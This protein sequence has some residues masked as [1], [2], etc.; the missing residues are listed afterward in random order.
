MSSSSSTPS[1]ATLHAL[2]KKIGEYEFGLVDLIKEKLSDPL[3][4]TETFAYDEHYFYGDHRPYTYMEQLELFLL[5]RLDLHKNFAHRA[6][7]DMKV[8]FVPSIEDTSQHFVKCWNDANNQANYRNYNSLMRLI[9]IG[10]QATVSTDAADLPADAV[11]FR[12]RTFN[13]LFGI[14]PNQ[15]AFLEEQPDSSYIYNIVHTFDGNEYR[16]RAQTTL[17][18]SPATTWLTLYKNDVV[19]HSFMYFKIDNN[20][21]T[22]ND[23]ASVFGWQ[24]HDGSLAHYYKE[25]AYTTHT[26]QYP[27]VKNRLWPDVDLPLEQNEQLATHIL[28]WLA[29]FFFKGELNMYS[30]SD[31]GNFAVVRTA[32]AFY[33]ACLM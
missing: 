15:P 12:K 22:W 31:L 23:G 4:Q 16:L 8:V 17:G 10:H 5:Q 3:Q 33:D 14:N 28:P 6:L 29:N 19:E 21:Y 18:G 32:E 13:G 9:L 30:K 27:Q 25:I 2:V 7:A 24:T 1:V 11:A 26:Q 20:I